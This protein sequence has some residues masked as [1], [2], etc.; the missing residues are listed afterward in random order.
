[1]YQ[2]D[3]KWETLL[4]MGLIGITTSS[5]VSGHRLVKSS[6]E[7]ICCT[8]EKARLNFSILFRQRG[9][10][11]QKRF[12]LN[13]QTGEWYRSSRLTLSARKQIA[14][15]SICCFNIS[16][17]PHETNPKCHTSWIGEASEHNPSGNH[18]FSKRYKV[19]TL[20]CRQTRKLASPWFPW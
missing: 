14:K 4:A 20:F 3:A 18:V 17:W 1:M 10:E 7:S 11:Q 16:V 13:G 5:Y 19:L 2:Q 15:M 12:I 6:W 8:C 9:K